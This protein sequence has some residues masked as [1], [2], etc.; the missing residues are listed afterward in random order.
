M[1]LDHNFD[2]TLA[3]AKCGAEWA[4]AEIYRDLAGSVTGYFAARGAS[5]PEDLA[6]EVFLQAARDVK[7]FQGDEPGFRSWLFVIAHR[8]L[9]DSWRATGRR[10]SQVPLDDLL[11]ESIGGNVEDEAIDSLVTGELLWAFHRLTEDQRSVIALRIIGNLSLEDTAR[12]LG[13]RVVAIKAL[14]RRGLK[15]LKDTLP[16][17][18]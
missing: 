2:S 4:W 13:R 18:E 1:S 6:S 14:Q 11:W 15:T 3:A 5:D 12:V 10:P 17:V 7:S 8:R 9:V 16:R